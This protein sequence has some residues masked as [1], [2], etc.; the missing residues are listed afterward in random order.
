MIP[1]INLMENFWILKDKDREL[2]YELK[3]LERDTRDFI[4]EKLGFNLVTNQKLVKLEKVPENPAAWMGIKSFI[5]PMDYVLLCLLLSFLEDKT[6]DEQFLLS[7]IT[8]HI[9]INYPSGEL[10]WTVYHNR[11][12]LIRVL[13]FALNMSFIKIDDGDLDMF[14][15]DYN[16]EVLYE[17]TGIS[18]YFIRS[19]SRQITNFST[20]DEILNSE[21]LF[22]DEDKGIIRRMRVYRSL[23]L[24]VAVY[25]N[26]IS[27]FEYIKRQRHI[28]QS[29]IEKYLEGNLHIYK[30][31]AFVAVDDYRY[32]NAFPEDKNLSDICLL[33][34]GTIA[35]KVQKGELD[36]KADDTLLIDG[37]CFDGIL[38]ICIEKYRELWSKEYRL[39]SFNLLRQDVLE[40]MSLNK[41]IESREDGLLIFPLA[42]KFKGEY[43][44]D[45]I[46]EDKEDE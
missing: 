19:F 11:K 26:N 24:D 34:C 35:E 39:K 12:S 42:L 15:E 14:S 13:N 3:N 1:F 44:Q 17:N 8:E 37:S 7:H 27:M 38:Q 36:L 30:N 20:Y 6:N 18:R 4:R 31:A 43:P 46:V 22:G 45:V 21:W 2:Y 32:R 33:I 40:Y 29:D 41:L 25:G 16:A 5:D 23:F 9:Q 10:D 28:L